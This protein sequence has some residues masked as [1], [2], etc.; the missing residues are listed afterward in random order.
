MLLSTMLALEDTKYPVCSVTTMLLT[1]LLKPQL[2]VLLY[3]TLYN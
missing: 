3:M 2:L 1:I